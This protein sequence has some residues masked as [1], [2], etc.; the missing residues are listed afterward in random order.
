MNKR[1]L[2]VD[3]EPDLNLAVKMVLDE[4]ANKKDK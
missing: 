2:I 1:V 3:Y 4:K